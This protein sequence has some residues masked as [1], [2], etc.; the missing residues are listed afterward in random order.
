[1]TRSRDLA[2]LGDNSSKLEQQGLVQLVASSVT[3]GASGSASVNSKGVVTFSGTEFI[4][5]NSVFSSSYTI[6]K[7]LINLDSNSADATIYLKMRSGTTD[8]SG[9][10]YNLGR[11]QINR[12][13]AAITSVAQNDVN[14]GFSLGQVDGQIPGHYLGVDI[15][16][17]YPFVTSTTL[18]NYVGTYIGT[19]SNVYSSAG[20]GLHTP[21]TS[22]DGVS[23]IASSGTI[24]G[25]ILVYGYNQ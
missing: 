16:L 5:L 9:S 24:T 21:A 22:Y 14:T 4:S 20:A 23:L 17:H 12:T 7:L 19:D 3:K 15:T 10:N 18:M 2:N 25:N 1:M 6:Y 8:A 13:G 11:D